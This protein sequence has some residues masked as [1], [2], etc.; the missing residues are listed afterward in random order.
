MVLL[1]TNIFIYLAADILST[2]IL[3]KDDIVFCS[4]TKVEALGYPDIS[5]QENNYLIEL[6]SACVQLDIT[7]SVLQVAIKLR[8][9]RK[10]KLGDSL[11]A[12]TAIVNNC[13]LWTSNT[14]DFKH[15]HGL[16]L[17]NPIKTS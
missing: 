6:L 3:P 13:D 7:E 2:K 9:D 8:Q 15:I 17:F 4:I 11:I 14:D 1:D 16:K 5:V 10:M 12:A